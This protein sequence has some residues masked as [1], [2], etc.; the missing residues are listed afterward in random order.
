MN[1]IMNLTKMKH[2]MVRGL[3]VAACIISLAIQPFTAS[4]AGGATQI[5]VLWTFGT[6]QAVI[7]RPGRPDRDRC[8]GQC[9][10]GVGTVSCT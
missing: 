2:I 10:C 1:R 4:A 5:P 3:L 6:F 9:C 7:A 8:L